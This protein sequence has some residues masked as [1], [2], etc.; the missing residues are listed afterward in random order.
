[1]KTPALNILKELSDTRDSIISEIQESLGLKERPL[2]KSSFHKS[3]DFIEK[4]L[5]IRKNVRESKFKSSE[6]LNKLKSI[7]EFE[8]KG[9]SNFL[10]NDDMKN[11]IGVKFLSLNRRH[12][13]KS[14]NPVPII[15]SIKKKSPYK[16]SVT[17]LNTRCP[18]LPDL[19]VSQQLKLDFSSPVKKSVDFNAFSKNSV[20]LNQPSKKSLDLN[21]SRLLKNY[22][23]SEMKKVWPSEDQKGKFLLKLSNL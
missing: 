23:H 17:K 14:P 22:I 20:D 8:S 4:K 18:S 12:F 9:D 10:S 11:E 15:K 16:Y 1:V 13:G 2:R 19:G 5:K 3:K 21:S 6:K 7:V